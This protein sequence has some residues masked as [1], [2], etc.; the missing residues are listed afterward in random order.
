MRE[1]CLAAGVLAIV[2]TSTAADIRRTPLTTESDPGI[3]V[4]IREVVDTRRTTVADPVLL[5]HGARVP[6]IASF[7][8][9]VPGGSLAADLAAMGLAIYVVDL[10]G[11]GASS[12]PAEMDRTPVAEDP[13]V[14]SGAAVRDLSAAVDTVLAR[15]GAERVSILGWAT[16]GHW[17]GQYAALYPETVSRLVLYNT[18]YGY[19]ADHPTLGRGSRL[20]LPDDPDRFNIDLFGNYRLNPA[21]SLLPGW[22]RSIPIADTAAWRDPAVADAYVA[23]ALASDPT[24]T[25]RDPPS[26]RAPSGALADSFLLATGAALWDARLISANVLIVRS[27][28]DFWSRPQDA[29]LLEAHLGARSTGSV[30]AIEIPQATHFVHLDRPERGR[31]EFLQAVA[32]FLTDRAE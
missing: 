12:R 4:A 31:D 27:E 3:E 32:A 7:D 15:T 14:R 1:A 24:S 20:A 5:V 11:Y 19:T 21:D 10:R 2:S 25:D 18:L 29:T 16:G 9:D 8:L 22:D 6:G 13:L 26:F 28:N 30:S 23:A 17:A